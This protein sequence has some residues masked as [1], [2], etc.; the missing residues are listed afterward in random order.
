MIRAM[1]KK[2]TAIIMCVLMM[3]ALLPVSVVADEAT[4]TN[5][6]YLGAS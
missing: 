4:A 1:R 5:K 3:V 2:I 6:V